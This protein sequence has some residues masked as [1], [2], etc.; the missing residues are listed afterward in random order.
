[1]RK[2]LGLVACLLLGLVLGT[3][4]SPAEA[5]SPR[6][7]A[8]ASATSLAAAPGAAP[9]RM[10]VQGSLELRVRALTNRHRRAKGCAP[11]RA[12]YTLRRAARTHSVTMARHDEMSHQLPG[13][14][15]FTTRITR[16][17]YRGWSM[18]A[19]NVA[20]GFDSPEAVVA[21]W[22]ASP[23]HRRNMLNCRL[24]D[25]GVGVVQSGGQLWWTQNFGRR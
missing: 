10:L 9:A 18:V 20:R 24:R 8:P 13:E 23:G 12:R 16:A 2:I 21:A 7:L 25:L 6:T 3:T 11:L 14:P 5:V 17:G 19:E 1:M 15:R 22:M 4:A